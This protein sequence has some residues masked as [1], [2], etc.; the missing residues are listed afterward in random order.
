MAKKYKKSRFNYVNPSRQG[1]LIYNTLYNSLT[2]LSEEEYESYLSEGVSGGP[3]V[4]QLV[5]QGILVDNETDELEQYNLYTYYAAKYMR[6]K[7][8]ITVTPTMECNARCFY[9]YEEGV[10]CGKMQEKDC[11]A[12]LDFL[13]TLDCS[14]G[15]D[16]TWFG[17]EPL[18]NQEWMDSFSE[19]LSAVGIEFSAL[20]ITNGSKIT[21][22]TIDKMKNKW[23]VRDVQITLDGSYD[24]YTERKAYTDEDDTVYYKV[25]RS[26]GKM[27]NAGIT[28]QVRMNVDR[29]NRESILK[30]VEDIAELYKE[31]NRVKCYPA[32]LTGSDSPLSEKEKIEFIKQMIETGNGKFNVNECLYRLPRTMAC[33][34]NQR[35]AYSIDVHGNVFICEHMLGHENQSI[36]NVKSKVPFVVRELSGKREECQK[37]V[38][39]PK[40]RGGCADSLK[41]GEVPCFTDKYIIKAYLELL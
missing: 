30:A 9:C 32:F 6:S 22:V 10:R 26:V 13:N 4:G 1:Y 2:R 39:L 12:I 19:S 15:I 5:A 27:A 29:N 24:E 8:H 34:Y 14:R 41:Q 7:P 21:D 31:N 11:A 38:F 40:C 18:L 23:N 35:D 20:L 25:L 3:C 36:G 17:G 37:C 33:Y 28:V 16:L